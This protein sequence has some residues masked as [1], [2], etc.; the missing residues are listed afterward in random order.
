MTAVVALIVAVLGMLVTGHGARKVAVHA[1][2]FAAG[3]LPVAVLVAT[4]VAP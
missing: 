4:V 1:V 3:G 2:A